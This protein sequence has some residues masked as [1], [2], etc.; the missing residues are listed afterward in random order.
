MTHEPINFI[1]YT[2]LISFDFLCFSDKVNLS[3]RPF[4]KS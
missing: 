3:V 1:L 2:W 4:R